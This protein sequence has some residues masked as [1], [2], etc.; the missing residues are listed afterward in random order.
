MLKYHKYRIFLSQHNSHCFD[1]FTIILKITPPQKKYM[2][3]YGSIYTVT[4]PV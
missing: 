2:S 3:V 1:E 4:Q